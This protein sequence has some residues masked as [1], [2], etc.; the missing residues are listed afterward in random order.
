MDALPL[1]EIAPPLLPDIGGGKTYRPIET[2]SYR[3]IQTAAPAWNE[4]RGGALNPAG[5]RNER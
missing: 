1:P 4:A 3:A 2:R 5:R